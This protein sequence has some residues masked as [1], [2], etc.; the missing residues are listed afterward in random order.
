MFARLKLLRRESR[1]A[2]ASLPAG[3]DGKTA[4]PSLYHLLEVLGKERV[5]Q[6]IEKALAN[7]NFLRKI[8]FATANM[9]S[10]FLSLLFC[11]SAQANDLRLVGTNLYDLTFADAK[12]GYRVHGT[13][14]KVYPQSVEV[15]IPYGIAYQRYM[16]GDPTGLISPSDMLGMKADDLDAIQRG[17][18]VAD[19][20]NS[21]DYY[22]NYFNP[23]PITTAQYFSLDPE[24]R[25]N[26]KQ[27]IVYAKV[28]ILNY[29]QTVAKGD[30]INCAVVPTKYRGFYDCGIPF[31]GDTNQFVY[32]YAVVRNRI[33]VR[34]NFNAGLSTS[35]TNISITA[36]NR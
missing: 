28:Y 36:T 11:I 16:F 17:V 23:P 31:S 24:M 2:G 7:Q 35:S 15:T 32:T 8:L 9:K 14:S 21:T 13:V 30:V 20:L 10:W 19:M 12:S 34:T 26:Y 18:A 29:Q 4:G 6:R 3:R 1:R 27:V 33:V 25:K 22:S 5:L